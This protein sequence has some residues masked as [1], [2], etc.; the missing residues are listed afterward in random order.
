MKVRAP[1]WLAFWLS[2]FAFSRNGIGR[3]F[4]F[5]PLRADVHVEAVFAV[6]ATEWRPVEL[7]HDGVQQAPMLGATHVSPEAP[8]TAHHMFSFFFHTQ[9]FDTLAHRRP[10]YAE[11]STIV[12]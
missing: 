10:I 7:F 6:P 12:P 8:R 2:R 5:V 9:T 3:F 11:L 4:V 1:G